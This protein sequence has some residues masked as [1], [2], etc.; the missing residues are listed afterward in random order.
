MDA[1]TNFSLLQ[2]AVGDGLNQAAERIGE[3]LRRASAIRE[4]EKSSAAWKSYANDLL[5]QVETL[6][7]EVK[8][9]DEIIAEQDR[10]YTANFEALVAF[11]KQSDAHREYVEV[12]T[13][14]LEQAENQIARLSNTSLALNELQEALA[15]EMSDVS[16]PSR[17]KLIDP[18]VRTQFIQTKWAE[19]AKTTKVRPVPKPGEK[20]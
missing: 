4:E 13:T 2:G 10:T 8:K 17:S 19:Y 14:R 11:S 18:A 12:L 5:R 15:K 7:G 3:G 6:Q 20:A 1:M 16:D 9:R